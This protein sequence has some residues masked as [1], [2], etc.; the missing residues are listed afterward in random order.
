MDPQISAR[1]PA[2]R[3][4]APIVS[5]RI[6]VISLHYGSDT[7]KGPETRIRIFRDL[8]SFAGRIEFMRWVDRGHIC[9][10]AGSM[11]ADGDLRQR[12]LGWGLASSEESSPKTGPGR[13]SRL[14]IADPQEHQSEGQLLRAAQ[15]G[16]EEALEVLFRRHW[17]DAHRAAFL[18]VRDAQAAEDIAQEAFLS[19]IRA[20][21]RF[22]RSRRFRP[23]LYRIV[24]NRAIDWSRTRTLRAEVSIETLPVAALGRDSGKDESIAGFDDLLAGLSAEHRGV[25]VLRFL[26]D[27]TPGEIAK[28]LGLPRGTVNSR[29]RRALDRLGERI[30]RQEG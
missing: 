20:L 10:E 2:T 13:R 12:L 28:M 3:P 29:L 19:A 8:W 25:I 21:G 27:Y 1:V 14:L 5:I 9:L 26:L 4:K 23:W 15:D 24:V 7:L 17:R 30:D 6:R 18:I 22:D 16:S 11:A